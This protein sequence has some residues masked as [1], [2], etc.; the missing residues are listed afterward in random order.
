M[1]TMWGDDLLAFFKYLGHQGIEQNEVFSPRPGA[2]VARGWEYRKE[3]DGSM[4]CAKR[5]RSTPS[6]HGVAR[7]VMRQ[8]DS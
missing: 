3:I 7:R 5:L 2:C 1:E 4:A 8:S 6:V